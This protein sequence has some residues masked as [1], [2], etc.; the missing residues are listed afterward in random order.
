MSI[1]LVDTWHMIKGKWVHIYQV[2]KDG[3]IYCYTD[4]VL[5]CERKVY[6]TEENRR[7]TEPV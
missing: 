3:I 1:V 2:G 6:G 4:G 5:E 7:M